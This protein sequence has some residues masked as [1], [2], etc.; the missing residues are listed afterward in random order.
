[1]CRKLA[2]AATA[3]CLIGSSALAARPAAPPPALPNAAAPAPPQP[4]QQA[5][6][7]PAPVKLTA[8]ERAEASRMDPLARAAFWG[9]AVEVDARDLDAEVKLAKALRELTRYDDALAA[10]DRV[11]VIDPNNLEALLESARTRIAQGQGFFAIDPA[12]RAAAAAPKDWRPA[13]LLAVALEQS[14]RDDEAL[15][16]HQKALALSPNNP[17]TLS[18]LAMFYA[19]H[20]QTADAEQLL[21]RAVDM[22][23][24]TPLVRQNLALILGLEGHVDEAE[25][26]ARK[27]LPPG[28]VANNIAYLR[29]AA[30]APSS[31]RS[32][33]SVRGTP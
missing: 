19:A 12:Q 33:A 28:M 21:R 26:L 23:G 24:A 10:T 20:G 7:A 13:S 27:D 5:P 3:L 14:Q 25:R 32:W 22:P 15:A 29:P 2:L 6:P 17:S 18:N 30:V 11:L 16:A 8:A 31:E 9:H 1:M 4:A